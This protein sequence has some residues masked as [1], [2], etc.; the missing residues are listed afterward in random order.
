MKSE[1]PDSGQNPGR[2]FRQFEDWLLGIRPGF[3]VGRD[4]LRCFM[5]VESRSPFSCIIPGLGVLIVL[6]LYLLLCVWAVTGFGGIYVSGALFRIFVFDY[7]LFF[8]GLVS[9]FAMARRWRANAAQVEELSLVPMKPSVMGGIFASG[10]IRAWWRYLLLFAAIETIICIPHVMELYNALP[11]FDGGGIW[12]AL[13][14][15]TLLTGLT[16]LLCPWVLAWFHF[17]SVRLAHWMFAAHALPRVPLARAG[18]A[19]FATMTGFVIGLSGFGSAVTAMAVVPISMIMTFAML[20]TGHAPL[21]EDFFLGYTVWLFAALAGAF[22]VLWLKRMITRQY[23]TAFV[24]AWLLYQWWGAGE[25]TQPD[26]YSEQMRRALPFWVLYYQV[27]E[28]SDSNL[29][30][31]KRVHTRNFARIMGGL[32]NANPKMP[33]GDVSAPIDPSPFLLP[34]DPPSE[35]EPPAI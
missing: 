22:A 23:E 34:R 26:I 10:S 32:S 29:P 8:F 5:E 9:G 24:K 31:S 6:G 3:G 11:L 16:I 4:A 33:E 17:E 7:T 19:N 14:P 2:S 27:Q 30:E 1:A 18:A 28:E 25:S 35:K 20:A 12:F 21:G 13:H 15:A